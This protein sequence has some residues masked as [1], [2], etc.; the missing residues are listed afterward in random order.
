MHVCAKTTAPPPKVIN[1]SVYLLVNSAPYL[2]A[3]VIYISNRLRDP[4][5]AFRFPSSPST[6]HSVEIFLLRAK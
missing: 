3:C 6:S 5:S 4:Q 1:N 2:S